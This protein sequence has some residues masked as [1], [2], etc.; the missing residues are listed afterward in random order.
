[1][2]KKCQNIIKLENEKKDDD[3]I[4]NNI[5]VIKDETNDNNKILK[6]ILIPESKKEINDKKR[7]KTINANRINEESNTKEGTLK[8][9]QLIKAKRNEKNMLEEKM[10]ETKSYTKENLEENNNINNTKTKIQIYKKNKGKGKSCLIGNST[11]N[12]F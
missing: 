8:I 10:K 6:D 11:N 3:L 12:F 9:L 4:I 2:A 1:M 5:K 7:S